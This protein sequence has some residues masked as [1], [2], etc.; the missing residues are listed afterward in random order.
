FAGSIIGTGTLTN[1][2]TLR[3]VGDAVLDFTGTFTNTGILDIMTWNG[4]LPAGF[5]NN[6]IVLDRSAVKIDSVEMA[7]TSFA[8]TVTAYAGHV[9]QLQRSDD[10]SGP[11][12]NIG[13]AQAG[14]N[15]PIT[16]SD[17]A[18]ATGDRRF[19]RVSVSP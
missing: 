18:G 13:P 17:P 10:L 6:G 11:W 3:L 16:L 14:G 5:V 8:V 1:T 2:G 9:Y 12:E 15:A 19:Y 4:V 7:G